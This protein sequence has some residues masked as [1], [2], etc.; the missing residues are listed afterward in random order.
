MDSTLIYEKTASGEE[1][2]RQRTRVVQRNL[3]MVLILVDGKASVAELCAKTG[4]PQ[5]TEGALRELEQGG[6]I[7]PLQADARSVLQQSRKAAQEAS[8]S[9]AVPFSQF[10]TFGDKNEPLRIEPTVGVAPP[11][12]GDAFARSAYVPG[13]IP[14]MDGVALDLAEEASELKKSDLRAVRG[15]GAGLAGRIKSMI[16]RGS[17][18]EV[19]IV[20]IRRGQRSAAL[21]WPARLV[22]GALLA[23]ALFALAIL[24]FPYGRYLPELENGLATATGLPVKIREMRVGFYPKPGLFLTDVRLGGDEGQIRVGE[25]RLQAAPGALFAQRL[26]LREVEASDVFLPTQALA[27][28]PLAFAAIAQPASRVTVEH[29]ALDRVTLSLRNLD[30]SGLEGGVHLDSGG[31]F[32]SLT[33]QSEDRGLR[34]EA[35][36]AAQG[37]SID[38]EGLNWRASSASPYL[39]D[40]LS[41]KGILRGAT[42]QFAAVEARLLDGVVAGAIAVEAGRLLG[43]SGQL[44][45]E[46]I[47]LKR[48][49]TA[50]ALGWQFDGEVDGKLAFSAQA[51]DWSSLP[52]KLEGDG[53]FTARRG[54][55]GGIDLAEALRRATNKPVLG[56]ETRFEQLSGVLHLAPGAYRASELLL[57]SGLM[58]STGTLAFDKDMRLRGVMDVQMRGSSGRLNVPV[59]IGGTLAIPEAQV[60]RR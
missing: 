23:F 20:P 27:M 38:V 49:G 47:N 51:N 32:M 17:D 25:M 16:R 41:M 13:C 18:D 8:A 34:L 56:G 42:L 9:A 45:Y 44:E 52:G 12:E 48:L 50:L 5:M 28:L 6:F 24:L 37:M 11:Q 19:R 26:I 53:D 4:N 43:V 33:L 59:S 1:A 54:T 29:F 22:F 35:R 36:P 14:A 40:S 7:A 39:F 57:T 55:L 60:G 3:R 2:M 15:E 21:G 10:S 46:R 31:S 30:L 58:Q